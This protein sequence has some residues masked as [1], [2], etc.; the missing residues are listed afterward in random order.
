MTDNKRTILIYY[1]DDNDGCCSAA[2]AGN[3]Y[4]R[5]EFEIKFVAINYGKEA[6]T[7]EEI[8]A[9]RKSMAS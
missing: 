7:E 2:V 5:N 8:K 9:A 3:N 4:D 1:H 6:W